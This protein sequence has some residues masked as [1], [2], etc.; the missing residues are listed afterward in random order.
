MGICFLSF[1]VQWVLPF[2]THDLLVGGGLGSGLRISKGFGMVF[3]MPSSSTHYYIIILFSFFKQ[4]MIP[5]AVVLFS[6]PLFGF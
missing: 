2:S 5:V 1:G 4:F 6:P 3:R